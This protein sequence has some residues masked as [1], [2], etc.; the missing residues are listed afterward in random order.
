MK[1]KCPHTCHKGVYGPEGELHPC[2]TS[3]MDGDEP[4]LWNMLVVP[5]LW[6]FESKSETAILWCS[7]QNFCGDNYIL[8]YRHFKIVKLCQGC[9]KALSLKRYPL[10]KRS[11]GRGSA[12][13][14]TM[15]KN[16]SCILNSMYKSV[17]VAGWATGR[18]PRAA[19]WSRRSGSGARS[20]IRMSAAE[21]R[22]STPASSR[23]GPCYLI[24]RAKNSARWV[25][26]LK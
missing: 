26:I 4:S 5:S 17:G 11:R 8:L 13:R 9:C 21:C 20:P 2:L 3:S 14:V 16:S 22:V 24:T 10:G 18:P 7:L 25:S 1:V 23:S 6:D 12:D 19:I 15:N